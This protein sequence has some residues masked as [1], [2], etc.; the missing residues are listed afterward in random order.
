MRTSS[1]LLFIVVAGLSGVAALYLQSPDNIKKLAD[2]I[3]KTDRVATHLIAQVQ[4]EIITPPP[5]RGPTSGQSGQLTTTGVLSATNTH[6]TAN[7]QSELTINEE[8]SQAAQVKLHSMFD[9]Q[10]FD[11]IAP[12]GTGPADIVN[13]VDYEY[14]RVGE[15]LALGIYADDAALVQAWMD[16]PGHRA[17]ILDPGFTEIGIAVAQGQFEGNTTWLAVQT[18]GLPASACPGPDL[19]L[20]ESFKEKKVVLDGIADELSTQKETTDNQ[21]N[22]ISQLLDEIN[23][24]ADSGNTKIHQGNDLIKQGNLLIEQNQVDAANKLHKDGQ[25]LQEEGRNLVQQALDKQHTAEKLNQNQSA[26]HASYNKQVNAHNKLN[27][28]LAAL[29]EQI[30]SQIDQ[31]NSCA[32]QYQ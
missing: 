26:Q 24:L 3:L 13:Q 22:Q 5:L 28:E 31:Y 9:E 7:N 23:Q 30:N 2:L 14:I 19:S 6:R 11:H 8:L 10:Y 20:Q 16:S 15:N 4:K 29:A 12:N 17:N 32:K 25:T 18:F 1:L 21:A 27:K